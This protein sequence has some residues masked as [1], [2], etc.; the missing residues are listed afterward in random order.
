MDQAL[1]V[2]VSPFQLL[3]ALAFQVWLVV[4]PIIIIR[5]LNY[6]TAVVH[7]LIDDPEG[8]ADAEPP[9]NES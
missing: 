3:L 7:D 9:S 1:N 4:F 2:S 6:L 5:K 8:E